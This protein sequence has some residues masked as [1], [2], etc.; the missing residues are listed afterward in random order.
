MIDENLESFFGLLLRTDTVRSV[1][2]HVPEADDAAW[3]GLHPFE[4]TV[5]SHKSLID[6]IG[7]GEPEALGYMP[8]CQYNGVSHFMNT[9]FKRGRIGDDRQNACDARG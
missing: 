5:R 1:L 9:D 2:E 8:I 7:V 4:Q 6:Q 3:L